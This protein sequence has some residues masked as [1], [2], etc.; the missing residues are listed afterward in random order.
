M[1]RALVPIVLLAVCAI[2]TAPD[3]RPMPRDGVGGSWVGTYSLGGRSAITF[4]LRGRQ[5]VVALGAGHAGVQKV[6]ASSAGGRVTFRVPGLPAAVVFHGRPEGRLLEGT[7]RQGATRGTF[8]VRRGSSPALVAPGLYGSGGSI[9]GVVDD[10][11]GPARLVDLETGVVHAIYPSRDHFDVGAGFATRTPPRGKARFDTNGVVIE[12]ARKPRIRLRQLEV[13]FPAGGATLSGTL[14]IP[15]GAGPYPAVAF[16]TGSGPTTRSYLPELSALLVR[17]G[18]AVLNYD[19]RGTGQSGGRY[20]GESPT[21]STIDTLA[22]DAAAAVRF[23]SGRRG[24]DHTSLGLAGHSQSGWIMPLAAT[25]EARIRFVIE[26]SG[27]TVTANENDEYQNLTGQ[28]ETP[29]TLS[30]EEID[31]EVVKHRGGVDPMPWIRGL[32]IPTIW[33][34][35]GLDK[36]IPTRLSVR[37]LT[38][39]AEDPNRDLSIAVFPKANHALVQTETGLTSEML[40]SDTWAPGLFARVG[41]WLRAHRLAS[42]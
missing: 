2:G 18:V 41:E 22:R 35:G 34:Y 8:I 4:E 6:P 39:L 40:Q 12:G 31:A 37:N 7:V 13:R 3:A 23:L 15:A 30:D 29:Q 26:F 25:R 38:P 17:H 24:L 10:P 14:T 20:P 27:P 28:G 42:N 11:Y 19:K 5:A 1:T 33:L 21:E 16:V 36:H 9:V 32:D